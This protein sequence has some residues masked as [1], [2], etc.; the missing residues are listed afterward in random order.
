MI[1]FKLSLSAALLLAIAWTINGP[2]SAHAAKK[3]KAR[4]KKKT[5]NAISPADRA[6]YKALDRPVTIKFTKT[7]MG[8][9]AEH[10]Q[11]TTGV[12]IFLDTRSLGDVGIDTDTPLTTDIKDISLRSALRLMLRRGRS[13]GQ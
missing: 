11:K 8:D 5:E 4:A 12:D 1:R 6:I 9:V 3:N 2:T 13:K 10:L 7:P